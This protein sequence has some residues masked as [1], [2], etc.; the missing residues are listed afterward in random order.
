[1][2]SIPTAYR[3]AHL[4]LLARAVL[5]NH[6]GVVSLVWLQRQLFQRLKVFFLQLADLSSEYSF[7]CGSGIDTTG[8]NGND[9]VSSVLQKVVSIQ[10]YNT[11]LVGLGNIGKDAVN[12]SDEHSVLERVS[13]ILNNRNNICSKLGNSQEITSR[14]VGEFNSVNSSFLSNNI[15]NVRDRGSGSGTNVKNLR[16]RLDPDVI[17][18]TQDG[19]GD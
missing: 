5:R 17:D 7:G 13:G 9:G 19:C 6:H 11:G 2:L 18:T 3:I 14:T 8:L 1:M 12:H 10:S 15:R 4:L 16:S